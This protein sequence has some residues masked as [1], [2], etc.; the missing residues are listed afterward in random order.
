LGRKTL[1]NKPGRI[2]KGKEQGGRKDKGGATTVTGRVIKPVKKRS[3]Q[4]GAFLGGESSEKK[5][6]V[7]GGTLG[8]EKLGCRRKNNGDWKGTKRPTYDSERW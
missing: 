1:K 8:S 6:K 5:K 2:K 4:G 7:V 3:Q